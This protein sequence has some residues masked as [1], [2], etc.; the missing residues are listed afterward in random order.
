MQEKE[1][2]NS[3]NMTQ[4]N[5]K[6]KI[7]SFELNS[8]V[9]LAPM[10]G[11]TDYVQRKLVRK[12][13]RTCLLTTEMVSSEALVQNPRGTILC[14]EESE[15]PVAFQLSGHKPHIMAKAAKILEKRAS[16]IDINMGCPVGKI[17]KGSDGCALMRNPNLASDIIKAVKDEVNLPVTCKFRLGWHSTEKNFV[18]FAQ[19]MQKSGAD[20]IT[21][22]ARTKVQ[23]YSG[24]AD[25]AELSKLK[26]AV[27]IPVFANGDIST[28]QNAIECL[29]TTKSDGIAIAR[30]CIGNPDLL[31]RIEHYLLTGSMI[32]EPSLV[33]KI[34]ILKEHLDMEIAL[35]GEEVGIKFMRKF[36]PYYIKGVRGSSE[37]RFNLVREDSYSKILEILGKVKERV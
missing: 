25:W 32:E 5:K 33:E 20:A 35:R 12:Y 4:N 27:D 7:G 10:A 21:V 29:D 13:S 2:L 14:T 16:I 3:E 15:H 22:H 28:V 23:L 9:S 17:V 36:Y 18:E 31:Y 26:N 34:D 11:I 37:F 24:K 8:C 30:G 1:L 6:L 19:L